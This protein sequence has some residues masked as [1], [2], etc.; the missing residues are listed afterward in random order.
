MAKPKSFP[1]TWA[2]EQ[3]RSDGKSVIPFA[4]LLSSRFSLPPPPCLTPSLSSSVLSFWSQS[5]KVKWQRSQLWPSLC[6]LVGLKHILAS[7]MDSQG[8]LLGDHL[9]ASSETRRGDL[10]KRKNSLYHGYWL[11]HQ[12]SWTP[13]WA[14]GRKSFSQNL[15]NILQKNSDTQKHKKYQS[16]VRRMTR[17]YCNS[18]RTKI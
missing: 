13:I 16:G 4:C 14:H 11:P 2:P 7:L 15:R 17:S 1:S 3:L 8:Y 10:G 5:I 6:P 12:V 9:C 18:S